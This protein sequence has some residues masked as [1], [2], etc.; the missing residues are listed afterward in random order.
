MGVTLTLWSWFGMGP[1]IKSLVVFS[2]NHIYCIL[3]YKS[4][5]LWISL[6]MV[7]IFIYIDKW[8]FRRFVIRKMYVAVFMACLLGECVGL[9]HD[10]GMVPA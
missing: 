8:K 5:V 7:F 6:N 1:V 2:S 9:L 4:V 10:T 3:G